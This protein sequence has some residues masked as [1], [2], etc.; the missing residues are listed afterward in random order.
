MAHI[1][2]PLLLA[3]RRW[4]WLKEPRDQQGRPPSDPDHDPTTLYIP[5]SAWG[6][7]VQGAHAQFWK[8]KANGLAHCVMFFQEG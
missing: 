8:I 5:P 4:D 7:E 6:R 3:C 1:H 2:P